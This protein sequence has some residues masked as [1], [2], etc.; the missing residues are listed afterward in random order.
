MILFIWTNSAT[1]ALSDVYAMGGEVLCINIVCFPSDMDMEVLKGIL[2]GGAD[3][4]REAG[5]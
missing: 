4:V 3:K 2:K 1:N 5:V